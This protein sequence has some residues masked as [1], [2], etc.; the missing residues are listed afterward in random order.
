[1]CT[2]TGNSERFAD[3]HA[4]RALYCHP[5]NKWQVYDGKR[6]STDVAGHM[7]RLAKQTVRSIYAE[8]PAEKDKEKRKAI[9]SWAAKSEAKK[10]RKDM[11]ELAQSEPCFPVQPEELDA[12]PWLLNVQNGTIDLKTGNLLSHNPRHLITKIVPVVYDKDAKAP[13]WEQF[14]QEVVEPDVGTFLQRAAGYTLTGDTSEKCLF[15][16]YGERGNNGKTVYQ[17]MLAKMLGDYAKTA[18]FETFLQ[19]TKS[20]GSASEDIARLAGA[21]L[22]VAGEAHDKRKINSVLIK[23]LTGR[24]TITCRRLHEGSF[25]YQAHFKIWLAGNSRPQ[26]K[27]GDN[28]LWDRLRLI[29]FNRTFVGKNQDKELED[30]LTCELPGILAWAI[31]GLMDWH[32]MGLGEP[33]EVLDSVRDYRGA[34]DYMQLFINDRCNYKIGGVCHR[35]KVYAVFCEWWPTFAEGNAGDGFTTDPMDSDTFGKEITKYG[36]E[37]G[38]KRRI[39]GERDRTWVGIEII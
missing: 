25:E 33:V 3:Q 14:I 12:D 2:D 30:K 39:E 29:D 10:N 35:K 17:N 22:V 15:N 20:G 21:R 16:I 18:E 8:A 1:M 4:G 32:K 7:Q 37:P 6:W 11:L 9:A 36:I 19:T 23:R 34:C 13:R 5:W 28:A 31:R 27:A 26:I 38:G 24:D